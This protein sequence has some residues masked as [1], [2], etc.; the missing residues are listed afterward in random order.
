V[1][2]AVI[3]GAGVIVSSDQVAAPVAVRYAWGD[4]PS[5]NLYNRKG[6]PAVP[7]RT[8]DWDPKPASA[9]PE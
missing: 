2:K 5:C 4:Y 8:D 3:D 7:F 9:T 6:L 1:A